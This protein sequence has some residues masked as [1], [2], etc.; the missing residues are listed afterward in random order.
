MPEWGTS[1]SV[2]AWGGQLLQ[3]TRPR[4][5][6]LPFKAASRQGCSA[7]RGVVWAAPRI[8]YKTLDAFLCRM[9]RCCCSGEH[10]VGYCCK[11]SW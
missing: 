11:H 1:G 6:P 10:E 9:M 7:T 5:C 3:A 8:W 2:G 4:L